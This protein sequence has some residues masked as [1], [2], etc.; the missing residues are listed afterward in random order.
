MWTGLVW[1][2]IG[3]G[4][5]L[6]W[7]RYWT[8]GF[9]EMLGNYPRFKLPARCFLVWLI[10]DPEDGGDKFLRNAGSYT[11]YISLYPRRRQHSNSSFLI[12]CLCSMI[13]RLLC[14]PGLC[15]LHKAGW[16]QLKANWTYKCIY[17]SARQDLCPS[18][19]LLMR[20]VDKGVF[21]HCKCR[22]VHTM[23]ICFH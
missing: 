15:L 6:L 21:M 17:W 3:T 23:T 4:G 22:S 5:E 1:L 8:F 14:R 11:D 9:H 18:R 20:D 7:I 19:H 10:F 2:R 16:I 12:N 13:V